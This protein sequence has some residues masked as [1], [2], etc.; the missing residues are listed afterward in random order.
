MNETYRIGS[1]VEY[2]SFTERRLVLIDK[3][4]DDV[5]G[6]KAGFTGVEVDC[7]GTPIYDEE[8]GGNLYVWG[9]DYQIERVVK[10]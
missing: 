9:Y 2:S 5:K 10:F 6:G 1:I 7:D 8:C 3:K 4:E